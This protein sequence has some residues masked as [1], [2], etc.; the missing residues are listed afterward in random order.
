MNILDKIRTADPNTRV[1]FL[2]PDKAAESICDI[3]AL[4]EAVSRNDWY[5]AKC[6]RTF[7]DTPDGKTAYY[8]HCCYGKNV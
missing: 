8:G 3:Q 6:T 5:C 2:S 1:L 4:R 7:P